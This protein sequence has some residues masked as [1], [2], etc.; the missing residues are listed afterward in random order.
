MTRKTL[1]LDYIGTLVE[2]HGYS[3][4]IS[5]LKLHSAL[6]EAGLETDVDM[7]TEA[8]KVAHEKYRKIRYEQL[9]EVTNAIW[10]S[11]ALCK[12]GS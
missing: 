11:E 1:I 10:V 8:Y 12:A 9:T 7:F 2:P 5:Q 3:L 6:K 4:E